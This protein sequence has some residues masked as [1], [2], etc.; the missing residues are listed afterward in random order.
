LVNNADGSR[1]FKV[2]TKIWRSDLH[3]VS[4]TSKADNDAFKIWP[5]DL[6]AV[7]D[8]SRALI[9]VMKI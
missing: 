3:A 5:S 4:I 6:R 8:G 7:A 9:V 2:I 1:A